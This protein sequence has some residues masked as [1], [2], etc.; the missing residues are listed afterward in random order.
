MGRLLTALILLAPAVALADQPPPPPIASSVRPTSDQ[1]SVHGGRTIGNGEVVLSAGAGWPGIYAELLIA[2]SSRFNLGF[3]AGFEWG[4][5]LLGFGTGTG[6]SVSF[7][8]RLLLYASGDVDFSAYLRPFVI[9][10]E[11]ALVG[12]TGTFADDL[13]WAAGADVGARLSY[14]VSRALSLL[15][16]ATVT[17][18]WHDV[19][20]G[21]ATNGFAAGFSGTF[22]VE[23]SLTRSTML[24]AVASAGYGVTR[25]GRFDGDRVLLRAHFGLAYRL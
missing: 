14:A 13:G 22:G 21:G 20:N 23:G 10:G 6:G 2:P 16:G 18:A 11:G 19:P 3:R 1:L 17:G 5:A 4:S 15:A 8:M 7:P 12:Q 25:R 9:V 24:F